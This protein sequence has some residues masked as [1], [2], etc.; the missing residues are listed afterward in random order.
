MGGVVVSPHRKQKKQRLSPLRR[1]ILSSARIRLLVAF[2]KNKNKN[3]K[4]DSVA[5]AP[6]EAISGGSPFFL[7]TETVLSERVSLFPSIASL[8]ADRRQLKA[9]EAF[10]FLFYRLYKSGNLFT[11]RLPMDQ[12]SMGTVDHKQSDSFK[13]F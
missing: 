4:R 10:L 2:K 11:Q 8:G 3:K 9:S 5:L 12:Q 6:R 13:G 1:R 7:R